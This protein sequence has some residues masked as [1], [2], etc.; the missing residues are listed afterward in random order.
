M[1]FFDFLFKKPAP[2]NTGTGKLLYEKLKDYTVI[3]LETSSKYSNEA[4]IIELAAVRIRNS[5]IVN[6]FDLLIKPPE[7]IAQNISGLTGITNEMLATAPPIE[8]VL[9]EYLKFIG[10]DIIIGHNIRSFDCNVINAAC[11]RLNYKPLTNDMID[12]LHYSKKC[13][14]DVYNY[15]LQTI[16][17]YFNIKYD[18]HR[19]LNDCIAN[20]NIYER[21][22]AT[23]NGIY[24]QPKDRTTQ[25]KKN[26]QSC[27][28]KYDI[29]GK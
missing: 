18:A 27:S 1:G 21:L 10:N 19:A 20:H 14:I 16:A 25:S 2:L 9:G 26:M 3:D 6:T 22:K 24:H 23:Y 12:T 7:P 29:V 11:S 13:D 4:S 28:I 15:R 8:Q 17:R 5:K